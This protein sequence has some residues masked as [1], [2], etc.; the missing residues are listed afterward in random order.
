MTLEFEGGGPAA[1]RWSEARYDVGHRVRLP[2][3]MPQT[4]T[5]A[6]E[7]TRIATPGS[8]AAMAWDP[9]QYE[10]FRSPRERPARDLQA[11]KFL[12]DYDRAVE[13]AYVRLEG[14]RVLF[15]EG[16][17]SPPHDGYL[18]S[19]PRNQVATSSTTAGPSGSLND[20]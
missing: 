17:S 19:T 1:E 9:D 18:P 8:L 12:E 10:R 14:D 11:R 20:S 2:A 5:F 7:P 15:R 16:L 6:P 3:T 13:S 4:L